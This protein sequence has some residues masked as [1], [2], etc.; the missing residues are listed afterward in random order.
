VVVIVLWAI[1]IA[2]LV[3]SAVQLTAYRQALQGREALSRVQARWAARAGIEDTIAVLADHTFDP[4]ATDAFAMIYDLEAA[5]WGEM[6]GA[7]YEILHHVDG[8]DFSGPM[9]EHSRYNLNRIENRGIVMNAFRDMTIDVPSSIEDWMDEDDEPN[10]LG[11]ERDYYLALPTP[12]EPRNGPIQNIAELELIAGIWPEYL[13]GEDWNLNNRLDEEENDST[14]SLPDDEPDDRLDYGWAGRLTTH[15]RAYGATAS[16]LPRIYLPRSNVEELVERLGVDE[17]QAELLLQFASNSESRLELLYTQ[18]LAPLATDGDLGEA[19]QDALSQP[20]LDAVMN[21]TTLSRSWTRVPG[22]VNINTVSTEFLRDLLPD[23][24][25]LADEIIYLRSSR[26]EGITS[27][28]T[29]QDLPEMTDE[30]MAQLVTLFTTSSNVFTITSRGRS[31]SSGMEV[32][33]I[34]TVDRSTL[35]VRIIEYREQ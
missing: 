13:R 6:S 20:Q 27:L 15:S 7:R 21:E 16:G 23:N 5:S 30:R 14:A 12:Y 17:R 24:E 18:G 33:I 25:D 28:T 34:A 3:A 22:R 19:M 2:T 26:P 31:A 8:T 1:A 32:E 11:V 10:T 4:I 29:L 9:D 35:P